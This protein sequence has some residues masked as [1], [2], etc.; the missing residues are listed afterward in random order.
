M[1]DAAFAGGS[2]ERLGSA[3]GGER[4]TDGVGTR[5][6]GVLVVWVRTDLKW[7]FM[8]LAWGSRGLWTCDGRPPVGVEAVG[9]K[10]RRAASRPDAAGDV[11][12]GPA[13]V[14]MGS[15]VLWLAVGSPCCPFPPCVL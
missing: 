7:G 9:G 15:N 2:P 1:A 3:A 4:R 5:V 13:A 12:S 11:A 10:G 6:P 14:R 8:L